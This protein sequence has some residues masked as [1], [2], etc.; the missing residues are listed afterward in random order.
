[1]PGIETLNIFYGSCG[2][3]PP[4]TAAELAGLVAAVT[5]ATAARLAFLMSFDYGPEDSLTQIGK[6]ATSA[7]SLQLR[8][9]ALTRLAAHAN[10]AFG[11]SPITDPA[12]WKALFRDQLSRAES[13]GRFSQ[14]W[15][16]ALNLADRDALPIAGH[17]L[18]DLT[19]SLQQQ[20]A[21]AA[22]RLTGGDADWEAFRTAALPWETLPE[23]VQAIVRDP[24][25]CQT[26]MLRARP[27]PRL[28]KPI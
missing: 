12:P 15:F 25:G 5:P 16:A 22:Y 7:P 19:P 10:H 20:V 9:Q 4:S 1:M 2:V 23:A 14:A 3:P 13:A 24:S 18:H 11:Y 27:E 21:C 28:A 6:V 26:A 17:R 8:E